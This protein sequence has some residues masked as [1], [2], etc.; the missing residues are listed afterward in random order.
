MTTIWSEP[1]PIR[2]P[3]TPRVTELH[4]LSDRR[5]S[6]RRREGRWRPSK[7]QIRSMNRNLPASEGAVIRSHNADR[8]TRMDGDEDQASRELPNQRKA[9]GRSLGP[10]TAVQGSLSFSPKFPPRDGS[11]WKRRRSVARAIQ[12]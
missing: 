3:H 4:Q 2:S 5:P 12:T 8:P 7:H 9:E 11:N 10:S 6:K 1:L